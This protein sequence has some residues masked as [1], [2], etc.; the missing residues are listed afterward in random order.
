[1]A[2][3]VEQLQAE[4]LDSTK[5]ITD[6]L[7][8]ALV[9]ARKL[10]IKDFETWI[11]AELNGYAGTTLT[12]PEYRKVVGEIKAYNPYN[13]YFMPIVID[14]PKMSL[15]I[16][17]RY[18][19]EPISSLQSL[20]AGETH[21][22]TLSFPRQIEKLL[23]NEH[24]ETFVPKLHLSINAIHSILDTV[25]NNVL[26]WAL[27]LEEEG[28]LGEGIRFNEKE[29]EKALTS[30]NIHIGN[31]QGVWGNVAN[32]TVT[33]N[34]NIMVQKGDF[35]SLSAF[36]SKNGLSTEDIEELKG[37]IESDSIPKSKTLGEKVGAWFGKMVGKAVSGVWNIGSDVATNLLASAIWAYYGIR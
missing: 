28:I 7:R 10:G 13:N 30:T 32:S 3:L 20:L 35:N 24:D 36:L 15:S 25:R 4:A 18:L 2:G 9:V 34:L 31:F 17:S 1:M 14:D 11:A 21:Y 19:F 33:Q 6:L 8:K 16:R 26:Q 29:K 22:L 23:C 27:K 5:P 12:P 37:A